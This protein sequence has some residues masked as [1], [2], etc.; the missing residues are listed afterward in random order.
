MKKFGILLTCV[1]A[2]LCQY[3]ILNSRKGYLTPE[4]GRKPKQPT[5]TPSQQQQSTQT[6]TTISGVEVITNFIPGMKITIDLKSQGAPT[7]KFVPPSNPSYGANYTDNYL[8]RKIDELK[9]NENFFAIACAVWRILQ[10]K[11]ISDSG[12][13]QTKN[14]TYEIIMELAA[15]S[16]T[17]GENGRIAVQKILQV[18]LANNKTPS[19]GTG[20]PLDKPLDHD[21]SY[22]LRGM[23]IDWGLAVTS[24]TYP[25]SSFD[26]V[27]IVQG[28]KGK[29]IKENPREVS[30]ILTDYLTVENII[31]SC[32]TI[33]YLMRTAGF[34][35][36]TA[37]IG[38]TSDRYYN[39]I[40]KAST[41]ITDPNSK[42]GPALK[43]VLLSLNTALLDYG[44]KKA[45]SETQ[46][47]KLTTI[48]KTY[49]A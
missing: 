36:P 1:L 2:T 4:S 16:R 30:K 33:R 40:S 35:T 24:G 12:V 37:G 39:F 48:R 6:E 46:R 32:S 8:K 31:R 28:Y 44:T 10:I 23:Y 25:Y 3:N 19:G 41:I 22:V 15:R 42:N 7:T 43:Q 27:T 5:T 21:K 49:G 9:A 29:D 45:Y 47:T 26:N 11:G 38:G 13:Y 14:R 20:K 18:V 17:Q 34:S